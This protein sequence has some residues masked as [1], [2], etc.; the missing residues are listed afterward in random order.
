MPAPSETIIVE[1]TDT[2]EQW[3]VKTNQIGTYASNVVAYANTVT[4]S[5]GENFNINLALG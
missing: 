1:K 5:G 2:F 3:R 4:A